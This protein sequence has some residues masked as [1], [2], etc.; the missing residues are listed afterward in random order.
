M[1][2]KKMQLYR[3]ILATLHDGSEMRVR[4]YKAGRAIELHFLNPNN[5]LPDSILVHPLHA[6][7][8]AGWMYEISNQ[9]GMNLTVKKW[10]DE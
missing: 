1:A 2:K 7:T 5:G 10:R 9:R 6:N 4:V 3:K 8:P